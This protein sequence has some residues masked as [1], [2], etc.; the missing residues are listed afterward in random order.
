MRTFKDRLKAKEYALRAMRKRL[1]DEADHDLMASL[2]D[3]AL[4]VSEVMVPPGYPEDCFGKMIP[5]SRWVIRDDDLDLVSVIGNA[6]VAGAS[7]NWLTGEN[8]G[9]AIAAL[10]SGALSLFR[11]IRGKGIRLSRAQ[12]TVILGLK[13]FGRPVSVESLA[14]WL[15]KTDRKA[16][17][18]WTEES[19]E[20][21]L[22][23]LEKARLNDGTIQPIVAADSDGDWACA[24]I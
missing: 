15:E 6:I 9:A 22:Y 16:S 2:V 11:Q 14:R 24:N 20:E 23:S 12:T 3:G 5:E 19:V 13:A 10:V 7:I 18:P 4:K 1:G 8:A 17:V 21:V